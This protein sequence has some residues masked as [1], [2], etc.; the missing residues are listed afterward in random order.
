MQMLSRIL[1]KTF[2]NSRFEFHW[3]CK[4]NEITHLCFVDNL[5]MF[6]KA[7]LST[8]SLIKNAL[9]MFPKWLSLKANNTK[10]NV[11]ILGTTKEKKKKIRNMLQFEE[12][13]IPFT[14]LRMPMV[15]S[16]LSCK[17]C[18]PFMDNILR[19]ITSWKNRFLSYAGQL[20]LIKSVL[21]SIQI[22][23][24]YSSYSLQK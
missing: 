7:E 22:Y 17:D 14:Y 13:S 4:K 2:L 16:K 10:S 20:M 15:S 1:H 8:I 5:F 24:A 19:R 12:R 18:K 21:F 23:W 9:H 6:Y 11:F 3:K